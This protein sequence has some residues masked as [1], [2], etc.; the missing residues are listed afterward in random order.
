M[1]FGQKFWIG[2]GELHLVKTPPPKKKKSYNA[3][4]PAAGPHRVA[5]TSHKA[6]GEAHKLP[7]GGGAFQSKLPVK[8]VLHPCGLIVSVKKRG[9][10]NV[11]QRRLESCAAGHLDTSTGNREHQAGRSRSHFFPPRV[12]YWD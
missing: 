7:G 2:V 4:T 10:Q 3:C 1:A 9:Q 11:P 5:A 8:L 6:V 12:L